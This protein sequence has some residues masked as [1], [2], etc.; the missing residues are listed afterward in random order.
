M[1]TENMGLKISSLNCNIL[2]IKLL[3]SRLSVAVLDH[4][5]LSPSVFFSLQ[6]KHI[7]W[8]KYDKLGAIERPWLN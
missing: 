2:P 1:L 4:A 5:A 8:L 3:R 7:Q 6:E